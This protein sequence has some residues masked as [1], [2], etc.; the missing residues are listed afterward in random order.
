MTTIYNYKKKLKF[1][2]IVRVCLI[3][4]LKDYSTELKSTLWFNAN[5][6]NNASMSANEELT[7]LIKINPSMN[8]EQAKKLLYQPC[9]ISFDINNF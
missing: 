9:N 3:P 5:D 6:F 2:N 8:L 4:E 1:N 7:N